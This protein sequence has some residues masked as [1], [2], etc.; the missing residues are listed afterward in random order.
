MAAATQ[1]I[2]SQPNTTL[3]TAPSTRQTGLWMFP[4]QNDNKN[5]G[6]LRTYTVEDT[7]MSAIRAFLVT[8]PGA[9]VGNNVGSFLSELLM[10]LIPVATL[11][12]F[13][14]ELKNELTTQFAGVQFLNVTMTANLAN[15][16]STLIVQI[17]FTCS[18]QSQI[19]NL[20]I[21]MPS[22]FD[23]SN[24]TQFQKNL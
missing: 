3:T 24:T 5:G 1:V 13:A 8:R 9:R 4:F 15:N 2:T 20:I 18:I 14:T 6:L 21:E 7:I 16:V 19:S 10:T 12:N 22:V 23:Q 11:P 17:T